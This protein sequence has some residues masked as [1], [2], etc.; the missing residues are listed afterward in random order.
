M[1][2]KR[3][4]IKFERLGDYEPECLATVLGKEYWLFSCKKCGACVLLPDYENKQAE[5]RNLEAHS[6]FHDSARV[7]K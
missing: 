1:I 6:K 4:D 3:A 7:S 5:T 2:N